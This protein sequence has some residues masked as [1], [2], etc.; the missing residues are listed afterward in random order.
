MNITIIAL[1]K[2]FQQVAQLRQRDRTTTQ[3]VG[4]FNGVGQFEAK[5]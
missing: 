2:Y 4:D 5:F 1:A 3:R